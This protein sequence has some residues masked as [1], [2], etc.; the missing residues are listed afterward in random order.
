MNIKELAEAQFS[1]SNFPK[2]P[3]AKEIFLIAFEMGLNYGNI[4]PQMSIKPVYIFKMDVRANTQ[5]K[6]V[7]CMQQRIQEHQ[8][9]ALLDAFFVEQTALQR[10]YKDIA[11]VNNHFRNWVKKQAEF[12]KSNPAN[13]INKL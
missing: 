2:T 9:F 4:L 7:I 5:L 10:T 3:E 6:D 8:Y 13:N 11:E 12:M 1:A